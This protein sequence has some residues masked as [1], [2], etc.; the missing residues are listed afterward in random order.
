MNKTLKD[1]GE[2]EAIRNIARF[3]PPRADVIAGPGD[4]CAV[5]RSCQDR[6]HELLLKSDPV[7]EGI[8]FRRDAS[9]S[10]IG[11]KAIGRV[12]SDIAAMGGEPC[13]ALINVVAPSR[14]P[15]KALHGIYRGALKLA[16]ESG[17]AIVGGD[18]SQGPVVELHV[19]A[20]GRVPRGRAVLRSGA[21]P[22]DVLFV[23][24]TLGG[25]L[26]GKHLSFEPRLQEGRFLRQWATS[27][28]DISDGLAS[29]LRHL[30][31]MSRTGA[32]LDASQIPVSI[33]AWRMNDGRPPLEHALFDGEDFELLF[34]IPCDRVERFLFRWRRTF[35]LPCTPVGLITGKRGVI[36]LADA[37]R[38]K[39]ALQRTGFQHFCR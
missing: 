11:H 16:K 20:V 33:A 29:D 34:T 5:V 3:L 30:V 35:D 8:H 6:T 39:M 36:E 10:A 25:S 19:F 12:L 22:G 37:N 26:Q 2:W 13:W 27:M 28:I 38:K 4:D 14:T 1:I 9:P 23:S 31:E 7:I 32:L 17:L 21:K 15:L 18:L 24:G